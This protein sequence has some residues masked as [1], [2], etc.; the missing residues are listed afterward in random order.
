MISAK[1]LFIDYHLL[2][3]FILII[4]MVVWAYMNR[5]TP[6]RLFI[7]KKDPR[8]NYPHYNSGITETQNLIVVLAVPL[9][10]YTLLYILLKVGVNLKYLKNFDF[11]LVIIGHVGSIVVSNIFANILKLQ[12]GRPRP[13]F[14]TVL[15]SDATSEI[16]CP[17]DFDKK[18]FNEEFKSFPSG[19]SASAMS[20]TL[21]L[22]LFLSKAIRSKQFWVKF[23]ILLLFIYP[24][25]VGSTRITQYRHH[26]DDVIMGLFVGST[27]PV[28]Y[29]LTCSDDIFCSK[30]FP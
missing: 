6:K 29:F 30:V 22:I 12:V 4:L 8:F 24:Y 2:D 18:A 25:M 17:D 9:V 1:E 19:H 13:D 7:P 10:I 16:I 3:F 27:L 15:G 14:F 5:V 28:V 20:G 23:L 26:P 21:F 11:L